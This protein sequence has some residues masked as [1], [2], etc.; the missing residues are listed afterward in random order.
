MSAL[1]QSLNP[2][3]QEACRHVEG[4]LLII[5]GAGS[6]KTRVLT[7][8][9]AFLIR[10]KHVSPSA[11]MAVTFTNK[12]AGE[13]K[14]RLKRLVGIVARDMWMGTFHSVCGR[15]LR[16]DI[17]KLG[18]QKN[19]VIFDEEDQT[20]LIKGILKELNIDDKSMRPMAVLE[21]I[22]AAKNNLIEPEEYARAASDYWEEKVAPVYALYQQKLAKNNAL[23]FDDILVFTVK[24]FDRNPKLLEQYQERFRFLSVDEYQD[25]N[26][27]Q[28]LL[29]KQL[30]AKYRNICVVGDEDQSIFSWRGA[31]F[32]NILNFEKDYPDAK[33]VKLEQNYRSTKKIL[34]AANGLIRNNAMR[35]GK[36]LWTANHDGEPITSYVA[37]D[38]KDESRFVIQ[39]IREWHEDSGDKDESYN[40]IVVLYRTNAQSRVLE[41]G[42]L[43]EAIPYRVLSGV[44]FYERREIKD[45]LAYLRVTYNPADDLS[46][47]RIMNFSLE[48]V[49]KVTRGRL[50]AE[51]AMRK[52]PL[53]TVLRDPGAVQIQDKARRNLERMLTQLFDF[54]EKSEGLS[55]HQLLQYVLTESGYVKDLER[56]NTEESL[57]RAENV[58]ELLS[59]AK[60]F[61]AS[62]DDKSLGAFLTQMSL[63]TDQDVDDKQKPAVTMMTLHAA[64]GLEFPVVF[65]VGLEEG[66]FPHFRTITD[67]GE[68]EEER[69][70]C[71]VGITRAMHKLTLVRAYRRTL[72]GEDF[73]NGPSRFLEEIPPNLLFEI[74]NVDEGDFG[75]ETA[76]D[77]IASEI[78]ESQFRIGERIRHP[79]WGMGEIRSISGH[80]ESM[81]LDVKFDSGMSKSLML[82]YAR[83]EKPE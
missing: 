1:L 16:R 79:K 43:R 15:I 9:I 57:M 7:H 72:Y 73:S 66:I 68:L 62:N 56:D 52:E 2:P 81:I 14:E 5:A 59:V 49:G 6:G 45:V 23:D 58:K 60:E 77:L 41:D 51:A 37:R 25:T 76:S 55:V 40:D 13:M 48:G 20:S 82:K 61:E 46:L 32:T 38:E 11:I 53:F 47:K 74:S 29:T 31:D 78:I 10:E 83:L 33:V 42:F 70:L 18:L 71:Y 22:S 65:I 26:K 8:R 21:A 44:R 19:F 50:E 75:D 69:R 39:K 36:T 30:A 3:Q 54:R 67:P 27:V 35:K 63:L 64:K 80:G 17:D 28:Y 12:A 24:L 34:E 4:P